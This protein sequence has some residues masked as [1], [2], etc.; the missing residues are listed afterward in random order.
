[1]SR[2]G[3]AVRTLGIV[4]GA[5]GVIFIG[6]GVFAGQRSWRQQQEALRA[7]GVVVDLTESCSSDGCTYR[8]LVEYTVDGRTRRI[9]GGVGSRPP[10]YAVGEAVQVM[11]PAGTPGDAS[12]DSWS[13]NWFVTALMLG[14]GAV[15][16]G[17]GIPL[18]VVTVLRGRS[19]DWAR[20]SG[21]PVAARCVE[22]RE[23][24]IEINGRTPWI[25]VSEWDNPRDG[26]RY[27]FESEML[28]A[29]PSAR[30]KA[31][32]SIGVRVDLAQPKRYW[33]DTAFL[34]QTAG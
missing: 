33:M 29:D 28:W 7:P 5:V 16:G 21:T 12:I 34:D 6:I 32:Q 14:M 25:V 9:E 3:S 23:A 31:G 27:R 30:V 10:A 20:T 24:R 2:P 13:E 22:V 1:M 19:R 15:F 18:L 11:Y 26:K 8:P 4:F 17:I